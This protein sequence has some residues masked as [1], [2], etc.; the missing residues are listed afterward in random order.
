MIVWLDLFASAKVAEVSPV[1]VAV[2]AY[3]PFVPFAVKI[4]EVA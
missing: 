1:A 4:D 2:I 3:V